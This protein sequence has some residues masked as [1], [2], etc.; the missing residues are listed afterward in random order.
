MYTK[1]QAQWNERNKSQ[2][3]SSAINQ[4]KSPLVLRIAMRLAGR[5]EMFDIKA[6]LNALSVVP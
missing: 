5:A 3:K 6:N 1:E 4:L 2:L